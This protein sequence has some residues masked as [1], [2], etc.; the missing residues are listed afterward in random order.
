MKIR[1][2]QKVGRENVVSDAVTIPESMT[3]PR[4]RA[5]T[6]PKKIPTAIDIIEDTPRRTTVLNNLPEVKISSDTGLPD[7]KERPNWKVIM[8][9]KYFSNL[10]HIG[11]GIPLPSGFEPHLT[12]NRSSSTAIIRAL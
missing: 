8:S 6:T 9:T 7:S 4:L 1:P 12:P 3:P 5:A 2:I 10:V 11:H